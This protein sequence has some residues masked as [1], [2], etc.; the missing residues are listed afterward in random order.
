M[1]GNTDLT[2]DTSQSFKYKSALAGETANAD[3]G[4][5]FVKNTKIVVLHE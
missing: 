2:V 5:S 1:D 3:G 4:N